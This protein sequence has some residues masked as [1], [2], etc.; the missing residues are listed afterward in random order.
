MI[1]ISP[2]LLAA[3]FTKLG[4]EVKRIGEAGA[5]YLHLDVMDGVFVPNISFGPDVI[6]ALRPLTPM[7]FDVHLMITDP[8]RY[9]DTFSKSGA[10]I[11]TFHYE[12]CENHLEVINAIRDKDI[13]AAMAI[14]PDTPVEAIKPLLPLLDMVLVMTVYPG[15]G[16]QQLIPRTLCKVR[17][18]RAHA[19]EADLS[20]RI[21][22]DGGINENNVAQLTEAGADVIVAGSAVFHAKNPRKV[23][24]TF[25]RAGED[26]PYRPE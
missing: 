19:I 7:I 4:E 26:F 17:E 15:F 5:D 1:H 21:E 3:D 2:S 20:L 16:G 14:S 13:R 25:R 8:I 18:L 24:S 11:I 23:I 9:I 22:V 6:H 10:D 12:S